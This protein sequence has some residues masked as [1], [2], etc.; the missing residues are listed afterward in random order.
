MYDRRLRD[1]SPLSACSTLIVV[2]LRDVGYSLEQGS[3]NCLVRCG[4]SLVRV[5]LGVDEFD[6]D[7]AEYICAGIMPKIVLAPATGCGDLEE[8][9][10]MVGDFAGLRDSANWGSETAYLCY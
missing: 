8:A 2:D 5:I 3:L 10:S 1:V 7:P 6:S 4:S 9:V